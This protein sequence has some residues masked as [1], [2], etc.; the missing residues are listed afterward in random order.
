MCFPSKNSDGDYGGDKKAWVKTLTPFLTKGYLAAEP[1]VRGWAQCSLWTQSMRQTLLAPIISSPLSLLPCS[2][3]TQSFPFQAV[4]TCQSRLLIPN[5]LPCC[6]SVYSFHG[7]LSYDTSTEPGSLLPFYR[8]EACWGNWA[9]TRAKGKT[10]NLNWGRRTP[11]TE[12]L[13]TRQWLRHLHFIEQ[14][15][16][17]CL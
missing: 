17:S 9:L 11:E 1:W 4:I 15:W 6:L 7:A 8:W 12:L 3:V 10:W 13:T 16:L 5:S 2:S 14:T